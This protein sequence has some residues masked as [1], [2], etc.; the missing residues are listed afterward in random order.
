MAVDA[1]PSGKA[2][3]GPLAG[4]WVPLL[5]VAIALGFG[6]LVL[7]VR[8]DLEPLTNVDRGMH[9]PTDLLGAAILTALWIGLLRWRL[10]PNVRAAPAEART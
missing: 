6:L 10:R 4:R 8:L 7:L 1:A 3:P 5:V 9:H 2:P